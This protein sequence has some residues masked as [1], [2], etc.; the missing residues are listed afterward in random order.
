M[1][2]KVWA[3][4]FMQQADAGDYG[5]VADSEDMLGAEE[6][7]EL[8]VPSWLIEAVGGDSDAGDW[9]DS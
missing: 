1:L 3:R 6:D 5:L 4:H 8:T 9:E 2:T 7:S